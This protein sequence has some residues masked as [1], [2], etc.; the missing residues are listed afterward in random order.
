M[1]KKGFTVI[2]HTLVPTNDGG[3]AL[4]QAVVAAA[5]TQNERPV[6]EASKVGA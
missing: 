1:E 5:L 3:I 6:G 4:G 2:S